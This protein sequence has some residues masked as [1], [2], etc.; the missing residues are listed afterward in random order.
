[1]ITK[2]DTVLIVITCISVLG[3]IFNI[4]EVLVFK[5]K[6]KKHQKKNQYETNINIAIT[7]LLYSTGL[8]VA[9]LIFK[10]ILWGHN[11]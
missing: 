5:H 6:Q 4:V 1:M 8:L 2:I 11:I 3:T 10:W 9:I 7:N